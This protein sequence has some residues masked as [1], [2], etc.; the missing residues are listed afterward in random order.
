[1]GLTRQIFAFVFTWL[2]WFQGDAA[3]KPDG[4]ATPRPA[5][6]KQD[7][8]MFD[9]TFYQQKPDLRRYGIKPVSVVMWGKLWP[10]GGDIA[11]LPDK[12]QVRRAALEA[13]S[14]DAITVLDIEQWPLS[15]TPAKLAES[16]RKY[17][18]LIQ[19]FKE[20]APA[21]KVGY[22]GVAPGRDYWASLQPVESPRYLAWQKQNDVM[23]PVARRADMLCPSVYTLFEDQNDWAKYAIAQ[24]REA[25]RYSAAKPVYMF[26][27]PQYH[28]TDKKLAGTYISG[29]YW[30]MELEIARKYADGVML[31]GGY[32][33]KWDESAP[34][35]LETK[36]FLQS[37]ASSE[38]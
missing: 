11:N 37:F 2:V 19:W 29:D 21:A 30:R 32:Q 1:M 33:Q 26:L 6:P 10:P 35:W 38:R 18:T 3:Q 36:Q 22:Y 31:W 27:W 24:I 15:G 13:S 20:A 14:P 23:A 7:F 16:A 17:Q 5:N 25:R 12:E 8:R 9:A 28:P 34:W 4:R